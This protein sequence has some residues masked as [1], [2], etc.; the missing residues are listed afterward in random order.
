MNKS[1]PRIVFL[2]PVPHEVRHRRRTAALTE[3]GAR[4]RV[5]AF[6]R[7]YYPGTDDFEY[8][9]LG[10]IAK[11][12]YWRR[13]VPLIRAIPRVRRA[14]RGADIIY[15]FGMDQLL[16]GVISAL[17]NRSKLRFIYEVGD[18]REVSIGKSLLSRGLRY[19]ERLLV[20]RSKL[21]VITSQAYL[22]GYFDPYKIAGN[23]PFIIVENKLP[24]NYV[25]RP[26]D[27]CHVKTSP[28][29]I[30]YFGLIRCEK[31]LEVIA[32]LGKQVNGSI[33]VVLRG[34]VFNSQI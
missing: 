2:L 19:V 8:E 7:D 20:R 18:I 15:A 12:Q 3:V 17:T 24:A 13:V 27:L 22:S 23:T 16:L 30:G 32:K 11:G 6:E 26:D 25:Q 31:S 10:Y 28:L 21:V 1:R 33:Q 9:P 4:S 5:L 29:T 14:V 34:Y